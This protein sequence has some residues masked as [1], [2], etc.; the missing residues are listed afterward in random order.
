MGSGLGPV[1]APLPLPPRG[2]GAHTASLSLV[3]ALSRLA[4]HGPPWDAALHLQRL[5]PAFVL[6][7]VLTVLHVLW[8]SGEQEVTAS[9]F[10]R[11]GQSFQ[12][13][14]AS[15]NRPCTVAALAPSVC[16]GSLIL[17]PK[18]GNNC[19][20]LPPS[21]V[22]C[23]GVNFS[24]PGTH[25]EGKEGVCECVPAF[26]Q[27]TRSCRKLREKQGQAG[28]SSLGAKLLFWQLEPSRN[29]WNSLFVLSCC[30]EQALGTVWLS[31]GWQAPEDE[32]GA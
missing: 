30:G 23:E 6:I 8:G 11:R 32:D 12:S 17:S 26:T 5:G 4:G 28:V 2:P 21:Q 22:E 31:Q 27:P 10:R 29:H 14:G 7:G 24:G 3:L 16:L 18:D 9:A 13:S 15:I 20:G 19:T 25:Q 1:L